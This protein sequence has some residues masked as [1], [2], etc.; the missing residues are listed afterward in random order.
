[1]KISAPVSTLR[2]HSGR[3]GGLCG[4]II[5]VAR[6]QRCDLQPCSVRLPLFTSSTRSPRL[7]WEIHFG[8]NAYRA[9]KSFPPLRMASELTKTEISTMRVKNLR[10]EL[11]SR[12]LDTAGARPLLQ[13]RLREAAGVERAPREPRGR[14]SDGPHRPRR[15]HSSGNERVGCGRGPISA[16]EAGAVTSPRAL[17][18]VGDHIAAA[19]PA[20]IPHGARSSTSS[21]VLQFDGGSRGNPGPSGAG[22]VLYR[23]RESGEREEM[24][25]TSVWVGKGRTCNEAEYSALI[26]GLRGAKELGVKTLSVEGDSRL[27]IQQMLGKYKVSSPKMLPLF[28]KAKAMAES[29]ENLTL[30]HID[31]VLNGRADALANLAMDAGE[32]N[33]ATDSTRPETADS[34]IP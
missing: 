33:T 24:W 22:A 28:K 31:R 32:W 26:E 15:S 5:Q 13:D 8:S 30:C 21:Y 7:P 6:R 3:E 17:S 9:R 14:S 2:Y 18:T 27:V 34:R 10:E 11:Q 25:S 19:G 12:G 20:G 23:V 29:F 16:A 1:M 4:A